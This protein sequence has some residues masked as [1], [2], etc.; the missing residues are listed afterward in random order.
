MSYPEGERASVKIEK[1]TEH[2]GRVIKEDSTVLNWAD[3]M[4][5]AAIN[6]G[7]QDYFEAVARG[8]CSGA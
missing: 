8:K 3:T 5:T 7:Y 4:E 2:T 1:L 6:T